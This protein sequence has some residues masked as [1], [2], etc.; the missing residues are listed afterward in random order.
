MSHY[1]AG[2]RIDIKADGLD[3]TPLRL[4]LD[5]YNLNRE[6]FL[7]L[8][9]RYAGPQVLN[10]LGDLNCNCYEC[11]LKDYWH[12]VVPLLKEDL[13]LI[14]SDATY[15]SI[16]HK[17]ND[18]GYSALHIVSQKGLESQFNALFSHGADIEQL[19]VNT[20]EDNGATPLFLAAQAGH[21]G[22]LRVLMAVG[23]NIDPVLPDGTTALMAAAQNSHLE[24][25]RTLRDAG[26]D[27]KSKELTVKR[28]C[29]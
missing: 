16:V 27:R 10:Q 25:V 7:N 4:N 14:Q 24:V 1:G 5:R 18:S 2:S 26:A 19:V 15:V 13:K 8:C 22:L 9:L 3:R 11:D 28:L 23:A 17:L 29:L 6:D 21:L 12:F 20:K